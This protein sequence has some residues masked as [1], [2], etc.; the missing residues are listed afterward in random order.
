MQ[1]G[2]EGG[3]VCV[4]GERDTPLGVKD[5]ELQLVCNTSPVGSV[6]VFCLWVSSDMFQNDV[7]FKLNILLQSH[8]RTSDGNNWLTQ[9]IRLHG[10]SHSHTASEEDTWQI[11]PVQ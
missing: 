5:T 7:V 3:P 4:L 2:K 9:C 1:E 8:D 10:G 11:L 6:Q